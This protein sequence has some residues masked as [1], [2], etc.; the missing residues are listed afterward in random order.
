MKPAFGASESPRGVR[1]C[2]IGK[3]KVFLDAV[4]VHVCACQGV[5]GW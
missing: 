2:A 1:L 4:C 3:E 5:A